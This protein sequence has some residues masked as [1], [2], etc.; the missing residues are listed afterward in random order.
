MPDVVDFPHDIQ[1]ILDQHC[2]EC[3]NYQRR[4][5][6]V[7]LTGDLG[8]TWSH[9][10]FHLFAFRQV[11]DGRNGLGN[12]PPHALG[13]ADSP[14]L[15]KLSKNHYDVQV[16]REEWHTVWNWLRNRRPYAGSYA[17]L[18]NA[19][20]QQMEGRTAGRGLWGN[21]AILKRRCAQCHAVGDANNDA[22]RALPFSPDMSK[23]KRGVTRPTG[24]YER[25][26]L[27]NDPLTKFGWNNL[28]NLTHPEYSPLILGPLAKEAG[29]WGSC[30]DVFASKDDPDYQ[31]MLATIRQGKEES[32]LRPR[33]GT[34]WL[35][36]QPAVHPRDEEVWHPAG[37]L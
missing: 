12:D 1:P 19:E 3:H 8:V 27:E 14:L 16:T 25:L 21:G 31:R 24:Y 7:L 15:D 10:Y 23:N 30:G 17:G 13:S 2:V 28:V 29:G 11:S 33:Y 9:S 34:P 32:D 26:V 18:R 6:G 22:G 4:E 20:E 37:R 36:P 35:S 5:G